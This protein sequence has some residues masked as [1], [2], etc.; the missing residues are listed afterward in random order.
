MRIV[1]LV[2]GL[3]LVLSAMGTAQNPP[4]PAPAPAPAPAQPS[5]AAKPV[6]SCAETKFDFGKLTQGKKLDHEFIIENKGTA[7]LNI[8]SVQP[9]CGCTAAAP[10]QNSVEPGKMTTIKATFD[11]SRFEGVVHKMIN[12]S[13]NDPDHPVFPLELTG[14]IVKLFETVPN[15]VDFQRVNKTSSFETQFT[16][17]GLEGHKPNITSVTLDGEIPFDASFAKRPD[18]DEYV[19]T[20]KLKAGLEPRG[21]SGSVI[22]NL[23]DPDMPK[24]QVPIRGQITGD[25]SF[26]P[27]KIMFGTLK[28][29]DVM[30]RKVL[31]TIDNPQVKIESAESDPPIFSTTISPRPGGG[32][33]TEV[34]IQVKEN[35]PAGPVQG[36]VKIHTTS[37]EKP[38]ISIPIEGTIEK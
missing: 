32:N 16:V 35:A 29:K 33:I 37:K 28:A 31:L 13:S 20:L 5:N 30:A 6:I 25:I 8:M 11:S 14:T 38:L 17:R 22:V 23:D 3:V 15:F 9:S 26:F 18:S 4:V 2:G 21:V 1:K 19:V 10:A 27:P 7:M 34:Q 36:T 12:V 24:L